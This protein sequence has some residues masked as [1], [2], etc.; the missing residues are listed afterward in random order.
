L[1]DII[2]H[3][4][5]N[6]DIRQ[7]ICSILAGYAWDETNQYTERTERRLRVL[8]EVCKSMA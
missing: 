6:D 3:L 4:D 2:F 5:P 7:K 8:A 1:Q